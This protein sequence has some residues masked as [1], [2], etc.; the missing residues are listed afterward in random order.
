MTGQLVWLITGS[1]SGIGHDLALAALARGD[2]VIATAREPSLAALEPLKAKGAAV[3]ALDVTA[4]LAAL[5]DVAKR[6]VEVYGHVDVLVN[7]AGS[8][9]TCALEEHTPEETYDH[10]NTN[11]FGA[12]NVARAF[13]P[14]M[15]PRHTGTVVWLGA[16]VSWRNP[17]TCGIYAAAKASVRSLSETL[18]QEI[19]PLGLRSIVVEPGYTRTPFLSEARIGAY[20]SRIEDYRKLTETSDGLF[21]WSSG[22]QPGDPARIVEVVV[23]FVRGE[24]AAAGKEVPLVLS[25][26]SDTVQT[27]REVCEATVKRLGEWEEVFSSTDFPKE[28]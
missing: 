9:S 6:A 24:G 15:R 3:L 23:D 13:L 22:K 19:S 17:F 1:S 27:T 20:E 8:I 16:I 21:R 28:G 4:P 7:N 5:H 12:L 14:F 2:N 10:F 25:L 26:G 18:N 11:V